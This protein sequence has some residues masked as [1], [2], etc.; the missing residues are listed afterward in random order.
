METDV[1][2]TDLQSLEDQRALEQRTARW[3]DLLCFS[4]SDGVFQLLMIHSIICCWSWNARGADREGHDDGLHKVPAEEGR[5]PTLYGCLKPAARVKNPFARLAFLP[6]V[7]RIPGQPLTTVSLQALLC[8]G[9]FKQ[10]RGERLCLEID[11]SIGWLNRTYYFSTTSVQIW[12]SIEHCEHETACVFRK[13]DSAGG[14]TR[15][16]SSLFQ[17]IRSRKSIYQKE[18]DTKRTPSLRCCISSCRE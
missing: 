8:R 18:R 2:K 10:C 6:L 15:I 7:A 1:C 11:L 17:F 16:R 5:T 9:L 4:F 12:P 13:S 3:Q 14:K